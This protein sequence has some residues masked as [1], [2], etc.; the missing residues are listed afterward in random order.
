MDEIGRNLKSDLIF[1]FL[2]EKPNCYSKS[3]IYWSMFLLLYNFQKIEKAFVTPVSCS[4]YYW[5]VSFLFCY[6]K[7]YLNTHIFILIMSDRQ[8]YTDSSTGCIFFPATS[9]IIK[10]GGYWWPASKENLLSV[11]LLDLLYVKLELGKGWRSDN[12]WK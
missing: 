3:L 8:F 2:N 6:S 12:I 7:T 9:N 10:F 1:A 4:V 11:N 5:T